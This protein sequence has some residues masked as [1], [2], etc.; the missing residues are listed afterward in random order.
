M[1]WKLPLATALAAIS[2]AVP[3][4]MLPA[5]AS[6]P[7]KLEEY[8]IGDLTA[9]GSFVSRIA[10]VDRG[11]DVTAKGFREGDTLVLIEDF[12]F[13]D[14]EKDRKTWRFNKV[15]P[16]RYVGTREDVVGEAEIIEQGGRIFMR[17]LIDLP[18]GEGKTQR[19]RFSDILYR[20]D[21][22]E[23][24]NEARVTKFGLPIAKVEVIFRK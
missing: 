6:T 11:F 14:G 20:G 24:I 13:D 10:N 17:Y 1:P 4:T 3:A 8:F 12:V 16:S 21:N 9:R 2:I 5:A 23:V 18:T 19:V 22:G 7:L 15:A